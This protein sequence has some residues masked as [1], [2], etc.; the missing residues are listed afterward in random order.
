MTTLSM[1]EEVLLSYLVGL[2]PIGEEIHLKCSQVV[3]DL[4]LR[5][6]YYVSVDLRSLHLAKA[7]RIIEPGVSTKRTVL[8]V[9]KRPEAFNVAGTGSVRGVISFAA[10]MRAAA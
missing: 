5:N 3:Q 9:L 8:V 1:R 10:E 4:E 2:A 7:I 6:R